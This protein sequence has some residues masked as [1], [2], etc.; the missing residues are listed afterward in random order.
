MDTMQSQPNQ[1]LS[2]DNIGLKSQVQ[3]QESRISKA[4][5]KRD[6]QVSGLIPSALDFKVCY[7]TA[8]IMG[9]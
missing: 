5:Q 2:I 4:I 9:R 6:N 7:K 3:D 1:F 8:F